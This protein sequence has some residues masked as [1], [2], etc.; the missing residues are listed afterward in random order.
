[1]NREKLMETAKQIAANYWILDDDGE[2]VPC[3]DVMEWAKSFKANELRIVAKDQV[4]PYFV[5]TVFLGIN[6]NFGHD[7]P[8][9]LFETMVFNPSGR[10]SKE[11]DQER[12]STRSE[13]IAG[14]R[15]M[16]NRVGKK[17]WG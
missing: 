10:E 16:V 9:L 6:H 7:G 2:A 14:H 5:S 13:A 1:M 3:Q 4:G 12:V 11:F 15:K 17:V 8:P